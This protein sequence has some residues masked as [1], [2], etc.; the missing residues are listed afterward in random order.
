MQCPEARFIR[1]A[2]AIWPEASQHTIL[3]PMLDIARLPKA[4]QALFF[5]VGSENIQSEGRLA[6]KLQLDLSNKKSRGGSDLGAS[7]KS[8]QSVMEKLYMERWGPKEA[9]Q[10]D[11]HGQDHRR[12]K[13]LKSSAIDIQYEH[14]NGVK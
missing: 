3:P 10:A 12:S 8:R 4:Q 2:V 1:I 11:S 9:V 13:E 5:G 14:Y 7:S 6:P